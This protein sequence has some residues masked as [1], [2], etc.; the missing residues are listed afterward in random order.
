M[1]SRGECMTRA[2]Q[3]KPRM[4]FS[5]LLKRLFG[6]AVFII[7]FALL[8][9]A[10]ILFG[11]KWVVDDE[12]MVLDA[13]TKI[14]TADGEVIGGRYQKHRAPVVLGDLAEHVK[15]A[16]IAIEVRRFY[17]HAGVDLKSVIRA[18]FRDIIAMEKVEV[19]S[20]ITPQLAKNLSPY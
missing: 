6:W 5:H 16:F 2:K 17:E 14:E 10:T 20:T 4:S 18:V 7:I 1:P 11:G 15:S 19:A 3:P 8:G 12:Q 13:T 9:Y